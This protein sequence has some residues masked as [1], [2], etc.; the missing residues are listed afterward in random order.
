MKQIY[1]DNAST[2]F[3]KAPGLGKVMGE[4]IDQAAYNINRGGYKGA[5]NLGEIVMDTRELL[6]SMF[7]GSDMA[8]VIFT[9]GNT[10]SVNMA[11]QG[12][13]RAGDHVLVSGMEHNAVVRPLEYLAQQGVEWTQIPC[14]EQGELQ[15][16]QLEELIRSNTKMI[17]IMHASNVCGTILPIEK[18]GEICN[19]YNILFGVDAAQ[20]AGAYAI[21]ME[22][23]YIDLLT[24]PAHK[25][26]MGPQGIGVL[27]LSE[28]VAQMIRPI[29]QGGT[30]SAS[31][32][33]TMPEFMPDKLEAGTMNLTGVVGLY[34]A[35]CYIQEEGMDTIVAKKKHLTEVFLQKL[36]QVK[37]IKVIGKHDL[38]N[39][40]AVVSVDCLHQDNAEVAYQLETKYGISTRCG[41]HCA[42]LAH[43]T[44]HTFPQGTIRFSLGYFNTVEEVQVVVDALRSI[45]S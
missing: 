10:A 25:S 26:L 9:P 34:H 3:P 19:K 2:S 33:L 13:L 45:V 21:N 14:N 38:E 30:G 35:L 7:H 40:C 8:N 20:S 15:L 24:M 22:E 16:E 44:L 1:F 4:Q 31:H 29:L 17:F 32:E 6:C 11:L 42:P 12:V 28:R 41:L 43:R 18:V 36:E 37:E 23:M 39:R 27:M 5:Y